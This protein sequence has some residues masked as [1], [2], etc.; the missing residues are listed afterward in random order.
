MTTNITAIE[1]VTTPEPFGTRLHRAVAERG[2]LCVGIDPHSA[3][4]RAWGL[5]DDVAGLREFCR[6]VVA[7]AAPYAAT[8][9]P[10]VAF[11]ERHGS[12]GVAVL[13]ETIAAAKSAGTLVIVDAKRGDIGSTMQGYADAFADPSSPLAGDAVTV[14]PYLGFGS[15]T[16]MLDTARRHG[17]GVFVLALTSNPEGPEVQHAI[18]ADGRTVAGTILDHVRQ[19]NAGARPMGSIGCVV[20]A[21]IAVTGENLD[22]NGPL[23]APGLGAQGGTVADIDR[24]FGSAR[25]MVLPSLSREILGTGPDE[26]AMTNA[27]LSAA[28]AYAT[29]I[30]EA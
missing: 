4:L 20:G 19:A 22:V 29:V 24:V 6:R 9:K 10:Q 30:C 21:T 13:E 12:R 5:T 2:P 7:A 26:Q 17:T 1:S 16:P 28:K 11:F 23:L 25:R 8:M 15:L 14:S 18:R 3:L 27:V